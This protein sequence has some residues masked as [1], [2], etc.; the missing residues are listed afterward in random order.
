MVKTICERNKRCVFLEKKITKR[1]GYTYLSY[2]CNN[3]KRFDST[4]H[5]L[6][7]V[8]KYGYCKCKATNLLECY[9]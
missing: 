5:P 2:W 9:F 4:P 1:N 6:N 7:H 8:D 3:P